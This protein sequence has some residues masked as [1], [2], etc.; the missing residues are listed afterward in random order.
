MQEALNANHLRSIQ[1]GPDCPLIHPLMFADDLIVCG[2]ADNDDANV[3]A[4]ITNQFC[5]V[6]GQTPNWN[7]SA[8]LISKHTDDN[9]KT[10]ISEP[11]FL[12]DVLLIASSYGFCRLPDILPLWIEKNTL[13]LSH[14]V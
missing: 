8:I 10:L 12:L 9:L 13:T 14:G 2:R 4:S 6:S 7:K 1:L 5:A 11:S 3:I